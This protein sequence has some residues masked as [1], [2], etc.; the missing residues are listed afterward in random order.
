MKR[1]TLHHAKACRSAII[2][3]IKSGVTVE[4]TRNEK[5]AATLISTTALAP[6]RRVDIDALRALDTVTPQ[7]KESAADLVRRMRDS[8]Y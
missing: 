6:K 8:G 4:M 2:D 7:Q 5:P 3:H 1:I